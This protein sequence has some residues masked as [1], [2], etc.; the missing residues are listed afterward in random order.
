MAKGGRKPIPFE[1]HVV[2]ATDRKH[3]H[4]TK[5][6]QPTVSSRAPVC[7]KDLPLGSVG[8]AEWRRVMRCSG[9]IKPTEIDRAL[10]AVY[11]WYWEKFITAPQT[12]KAA[13]M[14]QMRLYAVELGFS[15]AERARFGAS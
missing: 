1:L 14:T 3:R 4:G 10:L 13:D 12:M 6:D 9:S 7:S 5:A 15:R 2:R 11:C 8:R